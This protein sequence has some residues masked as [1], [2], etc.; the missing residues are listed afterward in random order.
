[1]TRYENIDVKGPYIALADPLNNRVSLFAGDKIDLDN[2]VL[3]ISDKL[4]FPHDVALSPVDDQLVISNYGITTHDDEVMWD[5]FD[6][7][8]SDRLAIFH[9][10][11]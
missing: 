9:V 6:E 3:T 5:C 10:R 2:P 4:S 7:E 8:R 11:P 1:Y